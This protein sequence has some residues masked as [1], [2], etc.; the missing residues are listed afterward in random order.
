MLKISDVYLDKQTKLFIMLWA[1]L[2]GQNSYFLNQQMAPWWRNLEWRFWKKPLEIQ[3]LR[4]YYRTTTTS[5]RVIQE[6]TLVWKMIFAPQKSTKLAPFIRIVLR[7]P[8]PDQICYFW[9]PN[10][11]VG[12]KKR[13]CCQELFR[14]L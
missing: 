12:L 13:V 3:K 9:V 1:K 8:S 5:Y 4:Q 10:I 6:K 11:N 2:Y 7:N 14:N